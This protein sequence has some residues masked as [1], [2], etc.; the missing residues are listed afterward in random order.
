MFWKFSLFELKLLIKNRKNWFIAGFLLLFFLL[1]FIYYIQEEPLSLADQKRQEAGVTYAAFEYLNLLYLD[2]PEVA[3]V[4]EHQVEIQNSVNMQVWHIGDGKNSEQYIEEG[5]KLNEHRLAMHDLG[6]AG[7]PEHL[8]TPKEDILKEDAILNYIRDNNLPIESASFNTNHYVTSVLTMFSGL[9]FLALVL[10][11]GN[12]LLLYERR[13]M[14]VMQGFPL[15]FIQKVASKVILYS[16][17]IFAFTLIGFLIG[18]TYLARVHDTGNFNFPV[19]IYKNEDFIAV[20]TF[21]YLVHIFIGFGL[22]IIVLLLLSILLNMLFKNAFA[23]ILIGLG[24]FLLPDIAIAAGLNT[25]LLHPIKFIDIN[26]LLSGDLA[27]ALNNGAID[28]WFA[29]TILAGIAILLLGIIYAVN[30]YLAERVPKKVPLEKA[31]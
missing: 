14:S 17:F 24:I 19:L 21:E 26:K 23:N 7:I 20:S 5:L 18:S 10:I 2:V 27:I 16:I 6:N 11:S 12:E 3:A 31:F 9:L 25:V 28:F 13:H 22:S 29:M 8:I 1:F 30:K 15:A 4:R